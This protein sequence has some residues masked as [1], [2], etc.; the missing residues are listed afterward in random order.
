MHA[1][2]VHTLGA[3]KLANRQADA[4]Q[5]AAPAREIAVA[6]HHEGSVEGEHSG[7]TDPHGLSTWRVSIG[8]SASAGALG[9]YVPGMK[10]KVNAQVDIM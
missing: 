4:D 9:R 1:I 7:R 2:H 5:E 8:E 10:H 6:R 3:V